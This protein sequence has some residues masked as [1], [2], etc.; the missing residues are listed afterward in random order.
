MKYVLPVLLFLLLAPAAFSEAPLFEDDFNG[1]LKEGWSWLR[2]NPGAWRVA[3]DA[4]EI[5]VEPGNMW[6]KSNS[7]KNVLLRDVPAHGDEGIAV[8][9][10]L[11]NHPTNQ[12]EQIDLVWYYD[13]SHMV[14]IGLELVHGQLS[15]V[16]GREAEDRAITLSI[17]PMKTNVI[18]VRLTV[19]GNRIHGE[20]QV[21]GDDEWHEGGKCDL[22][23]KGKPKVSIQ[24][25][26]GAADVEHWA[27]ISDFRIERA[28]RK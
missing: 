17:I 26:Q 28:G 22:P 2:E 13:D 16:M 6:G 23:V 24:A 21:P 4:L 3:N 8:S 18:R 19:K 9:A 27:R 5:R 1:T 25:Y 20:Y 7:A 12:Y 11:E 15:L 14:K 10:T